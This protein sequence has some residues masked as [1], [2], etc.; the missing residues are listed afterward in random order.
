MA[1]MVKARA[2]AVVLGIALVCVAHA[3]PAKAPARQPSQTTPAVWDKEPTSF[4]GLDLGKPL[5]SDLLE[6]PSDTLQRALTKTTCAM[7]YENLVKLWRGPDLGI[8]QSISALM[9]NGKVASVTLDANEQDFGTVKNLLI[10]RYGPPMKTSVSVVKAVAGGEFTSEESDWNGANVEITLY[11]RQGQ[12]DQS[13]VFV[14]YKPL[15]KAFL[16]ERNAKQNA[17]ASKL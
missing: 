13:E 3:A 11:Q 7:I 9:Y 12:I 4:L 1:S 15:M 16:D 14:Q 10:T 6:C 8:P 2:S 5:P 17:A